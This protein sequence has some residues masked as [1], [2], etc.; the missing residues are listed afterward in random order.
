MQSRKNRKKGVEGNRSIPWGGDMIP[1]A[2]VR[3]VIGTIK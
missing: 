1:I 2:G 3:G